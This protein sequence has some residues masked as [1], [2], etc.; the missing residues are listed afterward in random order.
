MKL[1]Y[2]EAKSQDMQF[3]LIGGIAAN[4]KLE[5]VLWLHQGYEKDT[6]LNVAISDNL[7][8]EAITSYADG[9]YPI[10]TI[11]TEYNESIWIEMSKNK[12][13][14]KEY[15]DS[16]T[17]Y[18]EGKYEWY[19]CTVGYEGMSLIRDDTLLN[20]VKLSGF[21]MSIEAPSWGDYQRAIE[22]MEYHGK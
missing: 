17:L 12:A 9:T 21:N 13:L 15:C 11:R 20:D 16:V 8:G 22:G 4:A 6:I 1:I 18:R 14:I 5:L 7:Q 2:V 19:L 3:K 10:N